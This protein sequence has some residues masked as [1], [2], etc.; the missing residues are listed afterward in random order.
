MKNIIILGSSG[1]IG[2]Q[3]VDVVKK[4][5]EL[6]RVVGLSVYQNTE[7]LEEQINELKPE[8]VAVVNENKAKEL[9]ERRHEGVEILAGIDSVEELAAYPK[10]DIVL[11]ALVGSAGLKPT[12]KAL[13]AGKT[14]ALA[15]KESMV[16]GGA[17]VKRAQEETG[18]AIL[19]VDS[20][21]NAIF[22]CMV[23]EK[24][25]EIKK[26]IITA[27]GGPFRGR[28]LESLKSVTVSQALAHPRWRMGPKITIDSATLMNKGLEIIE[29]RWLF[30]IQ[31]EKIEV[32]VH[33][34]SIIHSMVEFI[35]GSIKAHLGQ[36]DMR[37][38][39][40][41]A[42][43]Y[44]DRFESPLP[45]LDFV[46]LGN[47]SFEKPDIENF[48][49]LG[50]AYDAIKLG[51]TYPAVLNAANE[52][53][54]AAF[55]RGEVGFADIPYVIKHVLDDHTPGNGEDLGIILEAE[56]WARST[57]QNIIASMLR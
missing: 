44:P 53:A 21:H 7:A 39:I 36:T 42:L 16:A 31:Y 40:Q 30:D 26:L 37:I 54:V 27:S 35:D 11:N 45:S 2:L 9:K 12:L 28:T 17:V 25:K 1:S 6:F 29:A 48:P 5:P 57:A 33:P 15:N 14:L 4:H 10:A 56:Q 51:K 18:T 34:Q 52:E 50:Y 38:P 19:P 55:L 32:V 43:S 3:T 46:E 49:C 41:Y 24:K 8:V 13:R 47:L 20:E 23:G 22:Q